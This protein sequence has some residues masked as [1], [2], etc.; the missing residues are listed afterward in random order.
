MP[1]PIPYSRQRNS[2]GSRRIAGRGTPEVRPPEQPLR[3]GVV[4]ALELTVA[5]KVTVAMAVATAIAAA[6]IRYVTVT[7]LSWAWL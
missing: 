7:A 1:F 2:S 5:V 4:A 3:V 6:V